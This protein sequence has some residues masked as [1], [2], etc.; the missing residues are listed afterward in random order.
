MEPQKSI[1]QKISNVQEA[2]GPIAK[3]STN[4]FF[5]SKYFDINA[6][7]NKL[8]P[9]LKKE[10][11][12]LTQPILN[13]SVYSVITEIDTNDKVESSLQLPEI[14]DPQKLGS[15]ITY[16]RR[17]T[18]QSL[19]ALEAEDDDGNKASQPTP[20]SQANG[21]ELPWL[22][23]LD[24]VTKLPTPQWKNVLSAIQDGRLTSVANG[25]EH[26]K[27]NKEVAAKL[28]EVFNF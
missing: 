2:I 28:E 4:P 16:F 27:V 11:L 12:T 1:H 17:Y 23:H 9:I 24:K 3:D 6:I 26:D 20:G 7:V 14:A 19:L 15:C 5:K 8:N 13:G 22:N 21:E 18:L 10:G 25:R